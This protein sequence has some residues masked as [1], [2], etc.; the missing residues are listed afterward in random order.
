M[1]T[2][3]QQELLEF[4]LH[5]IG[6]LRPVVAA[7]ARHDRDLASQVKRAANSVALNLAEAFGTRK[8]THRVQLETCR[9]SLYETVHGLRL[10]EAWGYVSEAEVKAALAALDRLGARLFGLR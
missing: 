5:I 6:L 2:P 1:R 3:I 10:A 4:T 8:G 7:I 9:G